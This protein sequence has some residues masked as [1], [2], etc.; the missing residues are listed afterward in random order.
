MELTRHIHRA[1]TTETMCGVS[2]AKSSHAIRAQ[3][4]PDCTRQRNEEQRCESLAALQSASAKLP[5]F[6]V[7]GTAANT[8]HYRKTFVDERRQFRLYITLNPHGSPRFSL[9]SG[10]TTVR[11]QHSYEAAVTAFQ[12]RID[13]RVK[14]CTETLEKLE[15]A[16]V[17]SQT[18]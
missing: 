2:I 14:T 3:K 9:S 10:H 16:K 11:D 15:R 6:W 4:C 17:A 5:A 12:Y 1:G 13:E 18:I 8:R 7:D